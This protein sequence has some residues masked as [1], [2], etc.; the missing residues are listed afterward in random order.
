[1]KHN[2]R[3]P[4]DHRTVESPADSKAGQNSNMKLWLLSGVVIA[5]L[6]VVLLVLPSMVTISPDRFYSM[7]IDKLLRDVLQTTSGLLYTENM[8]Y[9]QKDSR[10][11]SRQSVVR[12]GKSYFTVC[13]AL[14]ISTNQKRGPIT[15]V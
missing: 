13:I 15:E 7:Y 12:P 9:M 4:T 6:L 3:P 14:F 2:P 8:I 1:M 5:I 10:Q 11:Y